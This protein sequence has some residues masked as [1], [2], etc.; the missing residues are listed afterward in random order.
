MAD[1]SPA[2]WRSA[3]SREQPL[4]PVSTRT[5]PD[6]FPRSRS[7]GPASDR[8]PG[9]YRG[10]ST[11][12]L[13]SMSGPLLSRRTFADHSRP[14][15]R[16]RQSSFTEAMEEAIAVEIARSESTLDP[17]DILPESL[18]EWQE[19]SMGV[20]MM[21][22]NHSLMTSR[23]RSSS[24]I[25]MGSM[26]MSS[27]YIDDGRAIPDSSAAFTKDELYSAPLDGPRHMYRLGETAFAA[28]PDE[29]GPS[30]EDSKGS[31][32]DLPEDYYSALSV[33]PQA[34]LIHLVRLYHKA[35]LDH[36][37]SEDAQK[38]SD[39]LADLEAADEEEAD[40]EL[41]GLDLLLK[42]GLLKYLMS[43][44]PYLIPIPSQ[45]IKFKNLSC[46]KAVALDPGYESIRTKIV[47][48]LKGPFKEASVQQVQ[49]MKNVTGYVM[50]GTLTLILGP[51]G[52][53]KSIMPQ[54][55][56]GRHEGPPKNLEGMLTYNGKNVSEIN[57]HRLVTVVEP[58]DFHLPTLTVKETLQFANECTQYLKPKDYQDQLREIM[59]ES[60]KLGQDPKLEAGLSML[61]LKRV[62]DK[63]IGSAMSP[64]L[65]ANEVHR[66][67]VAEAMAGTYA[68]Y[69]YDHFNSGIDD[70]LAFDLLTAIRIY[71]RVRGTSVIATM[72]QPSSECVELFDRII[73]LNLGVV[74]YQGPRQDALPYFESLGFFKPKHV[75]IA[76]F[77]EEVTTSDGLQYLQP[78]FQR[79]D[80]NG[81][82]TA[83]KNSDAYK[84][85][86]RVVDSPELLHQYWVQGS[87]PWGV[88]FAKSEAG[89]EDES[90]I[91]VVESVNEKEGSLTEISMNHTASVR[92]DDTLVA[93]GGLKGQLEYVKLNPSKLSSFLEEP[94]ETARLQLE[95]PH[96]NWEKKMNQPQFQRKYVQDWWPEFCLLFK[97]ELTMKWR[98]KL[99]LIIRFIQVLILALFMGFLFFRIERLP[100][101]LDMS[102]FRGVTFITILDMTLFSMGQLPLL[103]QE[104]PVYYKQQGAHFFRPS[105][106]LFAKIFG[107]IPFSL[108]EATTWTALVYFLTNLSISE[109]G[110]NFWVFYVVIILTVMHGAA[111][112]RC[113]SALLPDLAAAG[114][115][116][117]LL[118]AIFILFSGFL[119]PRDIVPKYWIWAFY[120]DPLQ[121]AITALLINEFNSESYKVLCRDVPDLTK[122]GQC[123]GLPDETVGHAFLLRLQFYTEKKWIGVSIAVMVGWLIMWSLI[124]YLALAK[125]RHRAIPAI[126]PIG[127][128]KYQRFSE[129]HDLEQAT[130]FPTLK[131]SLAPVPVTLSWHELSY[132]ILIPTIRKEI[133]IL[134]YVSGWA[135]PGDMVALLGAAGSGKTTLLNC[136][137]GRKVKGRMG[138]QILV[139]GYP[140]V[141]AA[142]NRVVGSCDQLEAY[143]I[144]MTVKEVVAFNAA[145][146]LEKTTTPE[147]R[148]KFVDE[149]ILL[150]GLKRVE[151]NLVKSLGTI[152]LTMAEARRVTIA[153]ELGRNPSVLFMDEPFKELDSSS[154]LHLVQTL[155]H[156]T[157]TGRSII[158]AVQNPSQR[159]FGHFS[160][161]QIMKRG[162]G[163]LVYFG[164]VGKDSEYVQAYFETIPG[165]RFCAQRTSIASFVLDVIG[166]GTAERTASRDYAFEYRTSDLALHNHIQLQRVKRSKGVLGP[167]VTDTSLGA[168]LRTNGK[169]VFQKMQK[170]YWRNVPYSWGRIISSGM[171]AVLLGSVYFNIGYHTTLLMNV[172]AGSL[173]IATLLLAMT[174]VNAVLPQFL[175]QRQN[176][177]REK[178][179][180]QFNLAFYGMSWTFAEFQYLGVAT[181]VNSAIFC[182]MTQM[183]VDSAADFFQYWFVVLE[184]TVALTFMGLLIASVCVVPQ[185]AGVIVTIMIGAWTGT[186]GVVIPKKRIPPQAVWIF[187]TNPIQ[188]ALNSLTS[189]SFYCDV[190]GA[191]C[192][193]GGLNPSCATDPLACTQCKCP[194]LSDANN[195]FVWTTLKD[196]R[197]LKN[198]RIGLDMVALLGFIVL[199][200]FL[201]LMGWRWRDARANR[202][203]L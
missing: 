101:S 152:Y 41:T 45:V 91:T 139:N 26:S 58:Q 181:L 93:T 70:P 166:D 11:E 63:P 68:V 117:G 177:N 81:F 120:I 184:L 123:I 55:L 131:L 50:P 130:D 140:R 60:L 89:K 13:I 148:R 137:A 127:V 165:T 49:L 146:N 30:G 22:R 191:R 169:Y 35:L 4:Y 180:A 98:N 141:Q 7:Y 19:K 201:T 197:T 9:A 85:V 194:R 185:V 144:F 196:N 16:T 114:G 78:G 39:V 12:G 128:E 178:A 14:P 155:K 56:A 33:A 75:S 95:R 121:Q 129:D 188:Y 106:Y 164:P 32:V 8:H 67:S 5:H 172:R 142:F 3:S 64:T 86:C 125:I 133:S 51:P 122:I 115:V 132:N 34:T 154:S 173:Y 157:N 176:Y 17:T 156:I 52:C 42:N 126:A 134:H 21:K 28:G 84:D 161:V 171:I 65:T 195:A 96:T 147:Q 202:K 175:V 186:S 83:Y 62:V 94:P 124:N 203:N 103:F 174:N 53:G 73:L 71:T 167:E 79:L 187:W 136:L 160:S 48:S 158:A 183:A 135:A 113:L 116:L 72:V 6:E 118:V 59:G 170:Y 80:L 76:E 44:N 107:S 153:A 97:R 100:D 54:V 112:V 92:K 20:Q 200:R 36:G 10:G 77:L 31:V 198:D 119:V 27:R 105:T 199:F 23:R 1:S 57:H 149:I 25:S 193:N 47:S 190:D 189:L 15:L 111:V 69:V 143:S 192:L 66:V 37:L 108:A 168:S 46:T 163:E 18:G 88:T 74:V 138:G 87:Q 24:Q 104:R 159:I 99:S 150:V 40:M 110:W 82:E 90:P 162:G 145:L 38:I 182:L 43:I 102:Q 109:G 61:G 2:P 179:S 151:N 29:K